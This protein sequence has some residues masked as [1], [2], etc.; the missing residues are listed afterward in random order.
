MT[1]SNWF[2]EEP[3]PTAVAGQA[4]RLLMAG[5]GH[6]LALL[7]A[8]ALY[9]A[10]L[11]GAILW[12][13][14]WYAPE[15]VLRIVEADRDTTGTPRPRRE[16]AEYVRK[17]VF[18]SD[19]MLDVMTRHGLYAS[20]AHKNPRAALDSFREDVDVEIRENY[21]IEERPIGAAPR[22]ARLIVRFHNA[23]PTVAVSVTRE[24][25][26]LVVKREQATRKGEAL[27]AA[28]LAKDQLDEARQALSLRRST[29][30]SMR[31]ELDR[32]SAPDLERRIA[33]IGLLGSLPALELRQDERERREASLALGAV[34]EERGIGMTFEVVNDASLPTDVG[35][36]SRRV[37]VGGTAFAFGLPLLAI[38]VGA[39]APRRT[40]S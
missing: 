4:G 23:D 5:L 39:F 37:F 38:A 15:Y 7:I 9:A 14:Y 19:P 34:L 13:K 8:A 36:R 29:V 32:G 22:S 35:A 27:R 40:R 26:E 33:F 6:K 30:A 12:T 18:T 20:L 11:A 25:G 21:F 3:R 17:A 10:A 24:L 1:I 16:L 31:A 28:E 2:D